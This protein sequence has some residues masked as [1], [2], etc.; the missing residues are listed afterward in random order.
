M[1]FITI[2]LFAVLVGCGEQEVSADTAST[3]SASADY[4]AKQ[5]AK[6]E[7][8]LNSDDQP[9]QITAT[10]VT[11][12]SLYSQS[13]AELRKVYAN[14]QGRNCITLS[15]QLQGVESKAGY[16]TPDQ[17]TVLKSCEGYSKKTPYSFA[18]IIDPKAITLFEEKSLKA[19]CEEQ[20]K[21]V[22]GRFIK[23][24]KVCEKFFGSTK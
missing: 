21:Q 15:K 11:G 14:P 22:D 6:V 5:K 24:A 13:V 9:E 17:S 10:A 12:N 2:F 8:A 18:E 23:R 1:R 19:T 4:V 7:D 3:N 20:E 16:N